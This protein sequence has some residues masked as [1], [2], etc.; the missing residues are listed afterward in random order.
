MS[1]PLAS[2]PGLLMMPPHLAQLAAIVAAGSG[3]Y[4]LLGLV[5]EVWALG[6]LV[7][8]KLGR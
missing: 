2:V 4:L 6:R 3:P 8:R 5:E 1:Q 7:G